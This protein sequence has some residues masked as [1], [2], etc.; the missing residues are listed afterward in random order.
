MNHEKF[1]SVDRIELSKESAE[2]LGKTATSL[3]HDIT[4][5]TIDDRT[6]ERET[7]AREELEYWASEYRDIELAFSKREKK[8]DLKE[9]QKWEAEARMAFS[10]VEKAERDCHFASLYEKDA[11]EKLA[12]VEG[13]DSIEAYAGNFYDERNQ[14]LADVILASNNEDAKQDKNIVMGLHKFVAEYIHVCNDSELRRT[15]PLSYQKRR[16]KRHNDMIERIN[17]INHLAEKYGVD[18]L[19]FRDFKTNDFAYDSRL[20]RTGETNARAEY[21]R[22]SVENYVRTAFSKDFYDSEKGKGDLYYDQNKSI[23]AQFHSGN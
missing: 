14:K 1:E 13:K 7:E 10:N 22:S 17:E 18:R 21:D 15:D 9:Y 12:A 23:V 20:D 2:R 5:Q 19:I 16:Q 4:E 3:V 6:K 8:A 11:T